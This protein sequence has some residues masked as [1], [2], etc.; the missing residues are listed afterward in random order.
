M[1]WPFNSTEPA[2]ASSPNS[3]HSQSASM[4]DLVV[5]DSTTSDLVSSLGS[6]KDSGMAGLERSPIFALDQLKQAGVPFEK[7]LSPYLQMDPTVF[8]EST[9]Q[10]IF[11]LTTRWH[12]IING[13]IMLHIFMY[14]IPGESKGELEF[15]MGRIGWAVLGGYMLGSIRGILPELRNPNTRQLPFKPFMTRLMNSSVKH[16]SGFAHPVGSIVFM[17]SVADMIFGKLRAKDDL[18]AL[19]KISTVKFI[20][21]FNLNL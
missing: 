19:G 1:I 13:L 3:S 12:L 14:I 6:D 4:S 16:G 17:F 2:P 11:H 7:Q 18:N 9:P 20:L 10:E 21:S 5:M 15:A 8:R